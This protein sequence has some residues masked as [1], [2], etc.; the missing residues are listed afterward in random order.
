[1]IDR[2]AHE[3]TICGVPIHLTNAEFALLATLADSPRRAFSSEHL[4][5]VLTDSEWVAGTHGLHV[6][7][8]RL[9]RKLGE[10]GTRPRRVVTVHGFGY[11]Y[12]PHQEPDIAA[13]MA[14]N[15]Q[16][17]S[18]DPSTVSGF[19]VVALDR[20]IVWASDSFTQLL[21][22]QPTDIQGVVLY[23]LIHPDDRPDAMAARDELDSGS[24]AAFLF[25]LRTATGEYRLLEALARPVIGSDG[26]TISFLGEYR[27]ADRA[28]SSSPAIPDS[29]LVGQPGSH[30]QEW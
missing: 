2:D 10:S 11:R 6:T 1:M 14:S 19:L 27:F 3:V 22:W 26:Q 7:V 24:P 21:G 30:D 15:T 29:I 25:H 13:A 23:E 4:T 28:K 5:K 8:S 17:L 9:R 20:T 12:E 18:H 16:P